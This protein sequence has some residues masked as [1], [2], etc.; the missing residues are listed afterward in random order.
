MSFNDLR[1]FL[2]VLESEGELVRIK[3]EV[4]PREIS[5]IVWEVNGKKGSAVLFENVQG[6]SVPLVA[7]VHG[8]LGRVARAMGLPKDSHFKD[9][10][11]AYAEKLKD[12][13]SWLEPVMKKTGPCKEVILKGDEIDLFKF[14]IF[15]WHP[16]D[17][18]PYITLNLTITKDPQMGRNVGIYRVHVFDKNTTGI[19]A[20]QMQDIGIHASLAK[21][22]GEN[23]IPV[24]IVCGADPACYLAGTTKMAHVSDDEFAFAGAL[25]GTPTELVKCETIDVDVPANAE[26]VVEGVLAL[27]EPTKEGPFGEW[28]EYY[29]ESMITPTFHVTC[30]THRKDMIYQ[31]ASIGHQYGEN[32]FLRTIPLQSNFYNELKERVIGFRDCFIPLE[33]RGYKAIVQVHKRYPGWGKQ[34][35][36]AAFGTGYG[37]ASVNQVTVVDEEIDIYN[38]LRVQFAEAT[39]V[40]P[41]RDVVILPD[42]GVYPLNPSARARYESPGTGL[43]EFAW[44]SKMGIDATRKTDLEGRKTAELVTPPKEDL[45]DVR[46]RWEDYGFRD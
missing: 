24:A 40:D 33:G 32:E 29:E 25:R 11:T 12:K 17:G 14:P 46:Q 28:M 13:S 38:P 6:S 31:T 2:N 19:M 44:C 43:T 34:A 10:R 35:I 20:L 41:G 1:E 3:R 15:Q 16:G 8:S 45:E 9:I 4:S 36:Y 7:N 27:D 42:M 23:S 26:F 5:A 39:R 18:G 37:T 22:R 30:I 21:K